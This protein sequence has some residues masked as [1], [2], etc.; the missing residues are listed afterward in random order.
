MLRARVLSALV[1]APPA[2]A[3]AWYGGIAFAVLVAVAAAIMGW[4]WH[5][6]VTKRFSPAGWVAAGGC[7]AAAVLAL[8]APHLAVLLVIAAAI[9]SAAL[10]PLAGERPR[11]WAGM[12]ALY[13]GLPSVALV[14]LRQD[15]QTGLMTVCWLFLLVWAT[16][17]GAYAAGRTIG[18]PLLMPS[19]SPKKTW[20]GLLGGMAASMAVGAGVAVFAEMPVPWALALGSGVLAVIAQIGDFFESWVKRRWGVK[21]SSAIIPGHGGVLDRVDG[22]LA[23]AAAIALAALAS[24]RAVLLWS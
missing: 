16:D 10:A 12:G 17:I 15:A 24:G 11:L 6:M 8:D 19:I 18:G 5:R 9:A 13:A 14:W 22:L 7:A 21:D 4:E 2:L 20:A 23:V 1:M 3:A